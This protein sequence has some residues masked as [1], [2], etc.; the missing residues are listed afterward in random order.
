MFKSAN[1]PLFLVFLLLITACGLLDRDKE[2]SFTNPVYANVFFEKTHPNGAPVQGIIAINYNNP[3]E[4][5]LLASDTSSYNSLRLSPDGEKLVYTDKY[6]TGLG[7]APQHGLYNTVTGKKE[8]LNVTMG[9]REDALIGHE[10]INVVWNEDSD[11]FYYTNPNQAFSAIQSIF[12]YDM[13]TQKVNIIKESRPHAIYPIDMISKDTLF[14]FSNEFDRHSYY[15]MTLKGEYIRKINNSNF[16]YVNTD[17]L[18]KKGL[19]DFEWNDSLQLFTA[20]Y[21]NQDQFARF[22]IIVTDLEGSIFEEYTTG[23][24]A[25][26]NPT[27]TSDGNIVFTEQRDLYDTQID[28]ELKIIDLETGKITPLFSKRDYP[29]ITGIGTSDQ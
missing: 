20:S 10:S 24:H 11:G 4:F 14:V 23:V 27:W 28:S 15:I 8:L 16:E 26:R 13:E 22:K 18:W 12:Y 3:K 1:M 17:G 9:G 7:S 19:I 5:K 29:E 6:V 21:F 2:V 25:N